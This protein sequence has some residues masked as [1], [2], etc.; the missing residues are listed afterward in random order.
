[1]QSAALMQTEP[2]S[3]DQ[4]VSPHPH[5]S[6]I[7]RAI[8]Y[9]ADHFVEQ[10]SL[11]RLAAVAGMAPHHFQR[12]FTRWAGVSPKRYCQHLTLE[13]AKQSLEQDAPVLEAAWDA[14]LS[15]GGRLHD[16]FTVAEAMTPGEYKRRGAG[17]TI[18]YGLVSSPFGRCLLASTDL[19][20]CWLGFPEEG[21]E[22]AAI[23]Q[24]RADW[25]ASRLIEDPRNTQA[26][27][28]G[29]FDPVR[30]P[31]GPIALHIKGT[32]W[33]LKVWRALLDIPEGRVASYQSVAKGVRSEKAARA[34]GQ[35][36]AAN[37][38]A[39][40]IPCHRV[41]RASGD[42]TNYR[43]GTPKKRA[44]LAYEAGRSKM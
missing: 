17:M 14:G 38:I 13:R 19:G 30:R 12:I 23:G 6:A 27:A 32:N 4:V 25:H 40:L 42:I 20:I 31:T 21:E 18:R 43:W 37:P 5:F 39:F 10:P 22:Q 8:D 34:V 28:D 9:L 24:F 35:A 33:Q 15:G 36:V 16:L 29:L 7:G 2:L 41:I 1:M 26:A 11:E 44:I 3:T